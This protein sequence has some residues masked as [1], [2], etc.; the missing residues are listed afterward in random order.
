VIG[1]N[2]ISVAAFFDLGLVLL[3]R[4]LSWSASGKNF[5][6]YE[7]HLL[8][9]HEYYVIIFTIGISLTE[10]TVICTGCL[11]GLIS[12]IK[13]LY[14]I[15]WIERPGRG[16]WLDGYVRT[17]F[18]TGALF[19]RL[20]KVIVPVFRKRRIVNMEYV[21][22]RDEQ[23]IVV[24]KAGALS[25]QRLTFWEAAML[26][27]GATIG[28]GVLGLAFATRH[29]GWPVLV[30]WLVL[31]GILSMVSMLYVAE[32]TMRTAEPLPLAGLAARYIGKVGSF[33]LFF[34]VGATS[35]CSLIAY[36]GGCGRIISDVFHI[37]QEVGSLCFAIPAACIVWLGLKATGVAEKVMSAGMVAILLV[38]VGA[39][40]FSARV[41]LEDI[42]YTNWQYAIPIFNI[43][44]FC[45]AVQYIVPELSRGLYHAPQ[46]LVPSI[47]VGFG[48]SFFILALVPLAVYLMIP[49]ADIG[50][51]ASLEWG[52]ALGN[53][54]FYLLVNFFAF[55][56]MMTSY[57]AI[58]ESFFANIVDCLHVRS[59]H[60]VMTRAVILAFI[61]IPPFYLAYSGMVGFVNAIFCA[62]TFGGIMMS[63]LPVYMLKNARKKG[64]K[65]P[66]FTCG[67]L[68]HPAIQW[69][70]VI[71]FAASG[72]Y[73]LASLV[74]MVPGSW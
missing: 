8:Y 20:Y 1:G 29:A 72:I 11:K 66:V 2:A 22:H 69:M 57:W 35:F 49:V 55:C 12:A 14:I 27:V 26:V 48:I 74:G 67:C 68:F 50:E 46:Q 65:E 73:A 10:S 6:E 53:N 54:I 41:P 34:S 7:L 5:S 24:P 19:L 62:G 32:T 61:A 70:V 36:T 21:K 42:M 9:F 71:V 44:V 23:V 15:A 60:N 59:E 33:I 37:S 63:I 64:N 40:F 38:L 30:V 52:R 51:V 3:I 25:I 28:S 13:V 45:Y 47:A 56:A 17:L 58:A 16:S 43:T 39:S 31:S 18:G 4:Q